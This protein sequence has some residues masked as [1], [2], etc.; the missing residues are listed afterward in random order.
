MERAKMTKS[1]LEEFKV[2]VTPE[3][4]PMLKE[5]LEFEVHL[6]EKSFVG[7]IK[8]T[9]FCNK[10]THEHEDGTTAPCFFTTEIP[11]QD[12][13]IQPGSM[14]IDYGTIIIKVIRTFFN[15]VMNCESREEF[16]ARHTH[17]ISIENIKSLTDI[18]ERK[19]IIEKFRK[20]HIDFHTT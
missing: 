15:V 11:E 19:I 9:F 1:L 18:F 6:P 4:I 2:V 7:P 8:I 5:S 14:T 20:S 13:D 17:M 12:I 3:D 10:I 16:W